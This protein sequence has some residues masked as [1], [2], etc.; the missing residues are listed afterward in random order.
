MDVQKFLVCYPL[1]KRTEP[2]AT[3]LASG[4]KKKVLSIWLWYTYLD[5]H[6]P[7]WFWLCSSV[8][9]WQLLFTKS[10]IR[11]YL[12]PLDRKFLPLLFMNQIQFFKFSESIRYLFRK[13]TLYMI[14]EIAKNQHFQEYVYHWKIKRSMQA[15]MGQLLMLFTWLNGIQFY[16]YTIPKPPGK[17]SQIMFHHRKTGFYWYRLQ[18]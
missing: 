13:Y 17:G 14:A 18:S 16:Y 12:M 2:K 7:D 3:K 15:T 1:S 9:L 4:D 5:N 6:M 10:D 8:N 11:W